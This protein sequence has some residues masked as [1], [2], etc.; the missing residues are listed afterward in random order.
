MER[1]FEVISTDEPDE[2][3]AQLAAQLARS[4]WYSG[5]LERAAERVELALEIAQMQGFPKAL[6][7]ALRA[8]CAVLESQNRPEA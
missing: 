6:T 5:D 3:L 8:K 7:V 4:Y 2:D 1:A